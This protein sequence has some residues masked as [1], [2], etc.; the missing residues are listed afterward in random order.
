M[1]HQPHNRFTMKL[2]ILTLL[3]AML[4]C[5][6]VP[7]ITTSCSTAPSERVVAVTTLKALGAARDTA[8]QVA[9]QMW[10]DGKIDDA[11]RDKIIAYHDNVFQPAYRLAVQ[12]VQ[13][14]LTFASPDL[15]ALFA[16]LQA[17]IPKN[18]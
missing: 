7:V 9:G 13:S 5:V 1:G 12:G 10:R 14:D 16:Q 2:R 8:M 11:Q 17:L 15:I 18:T 6:G 3:A 4:F